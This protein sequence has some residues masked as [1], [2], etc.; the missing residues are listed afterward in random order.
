MKKTLF[1]ILLCLFFSACSS[2]PEIYLFTNPIEEITSVTL[3][4]NHNESGE[5]IDESKF[6]LI[7]ELE[8]VEIDSF[9]NSVYE[10]R[11][12]RRAGGPLWGYGEYMAKVSYSNGDIEIL[13]ILN[14]E[15]IPNGTIPTGFGS[16]YFEGDG[17]QMLIMEYA[18]FIDAEN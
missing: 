5:G 7:R 8:K 11:T 9:M 16:Y 3:M 4:S 2:K 1:S 10:L 13:G 15:Y 17:L 18:N 12:H 6:V 14:I